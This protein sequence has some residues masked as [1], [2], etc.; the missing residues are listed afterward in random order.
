LLPNF[1]LQ[2][3]V[4]TVIRLRQLFYDGVDRKRR[5]AAAVH[6]LQRRAFH[7]HLGR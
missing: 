3:P 2:L 6:D 5:R 4:V 7:D 1:S